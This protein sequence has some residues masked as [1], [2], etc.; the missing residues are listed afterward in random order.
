MLLLQK[1]VFNVHVVRPS[2]NE[3]VDS[4]RS[5]KIWDAMH[6]KEKHTHFCCNLINH[7][8]IYD[9]AVPW[10]YDISKTQKH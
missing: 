1:T 9:N 8:V 10:I 5:N 4:Y 7:F 6:D 2:Q 3:Q